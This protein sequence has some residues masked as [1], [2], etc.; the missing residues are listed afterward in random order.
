MQNAFAAGEWLRRRAGREGDLL[1]R[2]YEPEIYAISGMSFTGGRIF[3][4]ALL[5]DPMRGWKQPELRA[6]DAA[7][8][9]AHPPSWVV[10]LAGTPEAIDSPE[11]FEAR[12][13]V[14]AETFG[15][16][17]VLRRGAALAPGQAG[18]PR[19]LP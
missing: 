9:D 13:Y 10:A 6:E 2:G 4:T 3:W 15:R 17:V 7:A 11:W 18:Q 16:F 5:T 1:V 8:I 14:R 19:P 12:G